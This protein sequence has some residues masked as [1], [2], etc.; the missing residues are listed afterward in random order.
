MDKM[1]ENKKTLRCQQ[2]DTVT[3]SVPRAIRAR[4][5]RRVLIETFFR[6]R[7]G[8]RFTSAELHQN[9][10]SALRTRISEI[11]RDGLC[12]IRILNET[13]V[14]S[15]AQGQPCER[16]VYWSERRASAKTEKAETLSQD[17]PRA[18]GLPLFDSAGVR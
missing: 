18:T 2:V 3:T 4:Q 8:Q 1:D 17:R 5:S 10:G 15:D 12:S 7:L 9:F 11:N 6:E 16:S 14:R 13:I